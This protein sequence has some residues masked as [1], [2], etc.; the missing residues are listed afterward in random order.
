M[1]VINKKRFVKVIEIDILE[2]FVIL[3]LVKKCS[4]APQ[5]LKNKKSKERR[6]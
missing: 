2:K 4:I 5:Q 1:I 6:R 3:N